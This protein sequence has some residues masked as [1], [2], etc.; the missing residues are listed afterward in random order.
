M[1]II[2]IID[3]HDEMAI[4]I[5]YVIL[6][7]IPAFIAHSVILATAGLRRTCLLPI[8]RRRLCGQS[9]ASLSFG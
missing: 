8:I 6:H 2:E 5:F 9:R 1:R 3:T 7:E 4:T